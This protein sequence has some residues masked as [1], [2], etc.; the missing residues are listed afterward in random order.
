MRSLILGDGI[1]AESHAV[2]ANLVKC[3]EKEN[4]NMMDYASNTEKWP[5]DRKD[6]EK[7]FWH[8]SDIKNLAYFYNYKLYDEMVKRIEE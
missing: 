2:G 5:D 4:I 1:P 3:F 7:M 6:D 8:H